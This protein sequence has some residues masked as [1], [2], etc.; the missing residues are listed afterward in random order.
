MS[1]DVSSNFPGVEGGVEGGGCLFLHPA[2]GKG[3]SRGLR[4]TPIPHPLPPLPPQDLASPKRQESLGETMGNIQNK[5]VCEFL[6]E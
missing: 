5:G 3:S 6:G 1:Q 4:G 2:G